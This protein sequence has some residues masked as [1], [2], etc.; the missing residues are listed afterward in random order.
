MKQLNPKSD[1]DVALA[2][3]LIQVMFG[4]GFSHGWSGYNH[5]G[6]RCVEC[7]QANAEHSAKYRKTPI[8]KR[9]HTARR[10]VGHAIRD[11]RLAPEPC[12]VC[13]AV[14]AQAHHYRGYSKANRLKVIWLCRKHHLMAEGK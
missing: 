4:N 3:M 13:G 7:S 11:R 8:G 14:K 6:C 9:K 10:D 2:N 12:G 5:H 1:K